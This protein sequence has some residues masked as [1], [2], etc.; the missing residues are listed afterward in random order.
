MSCWNYISKCNV[1]KIGIIS[2]SVTWQRVVAKEQVMARC[3]LSWVLTSLFIYFFKKKE[4]KEKTIQPKSIRW[5]KHFLEKRKVFTL[6]LFLI[7]III[8]IIKKKKKSWESQNDLRPSSRSRAGI[9]LRVWSNVTGMT[10]QVQ[11]PNSSRV[12]LGDHHRMCDGRNNNNFRIIR[13]WFAA[14]NKVAASCVSRVRFSQRRVTPHH[15]HQ[16]KRTW[17]LTREKTQNKTKD[18][19]NKINRRSLDREK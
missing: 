2:P 12:R 11:R 16:Q 17:Q 19:T 15:H 13:W 14:V 3:Q 8:I 7:L 1:E 5:K 10:F 4:E 9:L 18:T 6:H